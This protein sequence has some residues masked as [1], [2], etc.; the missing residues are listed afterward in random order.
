MPVYNDGRIDPDWQTAV[1]TVQFDGS[2][3]NGATGTVTLFTITGV[4]QVES[5]FERCTE[6]VVGA[7]TIATGISGATGILCAS[8]ADA[9]AIDA[10]E[11][12]DGNGGWNAGY[13]VLDWTADRRRYALASNIIWTIG[14]AN[15]TDGT[16]TAYVNWRPLSPGATLVPA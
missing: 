7:G 12:N 1:K 4:I 15:L 8:T 6:D 5:Y 10:N 14:S 2:A 13:G 3:G 16:I 11:L 9:T